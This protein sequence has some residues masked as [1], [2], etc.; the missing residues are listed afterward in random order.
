MKTIISS[1]RMEVEYENLAR[2]NTSFMSQYHEVSKEIIESGWY[3][4]GNTVKNFEKEFAKFCEVGF[5]VGV[6]SGLDAM[7][8]PLLAYKFKAGSEVIVPSNTYVA[9]IIAII[10]AG[11]KPVLVEPDIETYNI[12][13]NKLEEKITSK[14]VCIL[15][16]HLYGRSCNMSA[17]MSLADAHGLK[18]V[19][20]CAQ[21]HGAKWGTKK[22]GSYG[23]G[24]FS[25]YPTKNLGALGDAG[26]VTTH[27][28]DFADQI[29]MIRNYGSSRKY[30]NEVA[31][32]NSR[33]DELQAG[34]LS[35]KLKYI[36]QINAKKNRMAAY[37]NEHISREYIKPIVDA[38][39]YHVY[40]IYNI[41]HKER[42]KLRDFLTSNDVRTEIHYPVAPHNQTALQGYF[43]NQSF[44]ISEEIHAS[45]LSIPISYYHDE[46]DLS[47]VTNILNGFI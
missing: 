1:I 20:D 27:D 30:Y 32:I 3:I 31:G 10:K 29:K 43:D 15:P 9:S 24:A 36:D 18:V 42:D 41:R 14:T 22:V 40:H 23:V 33:L 11:L 12:D 35:V 45:T 13:P 46:T 17:I 6:A 7:I 44:P 39:N 26:A 19:E 21:A 34:F 16:V 25:F 5:C 37:Y 28:G 8:L 2:V 47:Y 38:K 4:L